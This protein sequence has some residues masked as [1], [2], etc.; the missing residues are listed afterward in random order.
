MRHWTP[1]SQRCRD[2]NPQLS[3]HRFPCVVYSVDDLL[4]R[5]L[6]TALKLTNAAL[7]K[8]KDNQLLRVLKAL[9][10]ARLDKADEAYKA[11]SCVPFSMV[12]T[13]FTLACL[14]GFPAA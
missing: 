5:N 12:K 8:H 1:G 10:L 6:Q 14:P 3:I 2:F 7:Q 4:S 9:A 13:N 11:G